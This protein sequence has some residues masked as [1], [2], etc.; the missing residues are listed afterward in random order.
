MAAQLELQSIGVKITKGVDF[1]I[2]KRHQKS[3]DADIKTAEARLHIKSVYYDRSEK[4]WAFQ[5]T[6]PVVYQ[7]END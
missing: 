7:P 5:K 1:S 4:S 2:H 6:D 3:F